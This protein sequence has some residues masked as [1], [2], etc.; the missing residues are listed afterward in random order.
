MWGRSYPLNIM[1]Q[2]ASFK[3]ISGDLLPGS[4][5]L[6]PLHILAMSLGLFRFWI[7]QGVSRKI[8]LLGVLFIQSNIVV[9]IYSTDG[10]VNPSFA[11]ILTLGSLA[12]LEGVIE[13]KRNVQ[14]LGATFLGIATWTR[15]D[16]IVF[17]AA[18]I[19][20]IILLDVIRKPRDASLLMVIPPIAMTTIWLL[21]A[22]DIFSGHP[23][24]ETIGSSLN[25][26]SGDIFYFRMAIL[27]PSLFIKRALNPYNWGAFLPTMTLLATIAIFATK[28][29]KRAANAY[30]LAFAIATS[31]VTYL[32]FY[33]FA[34][35]PWDEIENILRRTFDRAFLP[36]FIAITVL[37]INLWADSSKSLMHPRNENS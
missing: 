9:F 7:K 27:I 24:G 35:Q 20:S 28:S 19:A 3:L 15:P 4:K 1:L 26:L 17:S 21:F 16:G 37:C 14:I 10:Q 34:L 29:W 11:A 2:I 6:F 22:G 33:F 8:S 23:P 5:L 30:L 25:N 32:T 13:R 12:C 31:L 36:A 18:I